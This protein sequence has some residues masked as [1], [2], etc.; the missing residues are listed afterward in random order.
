MAAIIVL[1]AVL[2]IAIVI[3]CVLLSII[4]SQGSVKVSA[5]K[6]FKFDKERRTAHM[7]AN[8]YVETFRAKDQKE[9][10]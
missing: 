10:A 7:N 3:I 9:D 2:L 5:G 4:K 1:S 6:S 8:V